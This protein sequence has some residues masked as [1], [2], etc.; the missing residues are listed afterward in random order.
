MP[1]FLRAAL[2]ALTLCAQDYKVGDRVEANDI[3]W[4]KGTIVGLG[5]GSMQGYFLVKYDA[6]SSQRY[7]KP[8]DLRPGG[9]PDAPKTYPAYNVGD[10][11]EGYDLGWYAARV[12]QVRPGK[13]APEYL[14]QYEKYNSAR[15]YHPKDMRAFAPQ[16]P[17]AQITTGPRTGKYPVYA[18]GANAAN[19]LFLTYLEILPGNKYRG[20]SGEGT[21][22]FNAATSTVEWLTGPLA[23]P[24]WGGKFSVEGK[25]HRIEL[26]AR[27]VATNSD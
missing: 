17:T 19:P 8:K 4:Y 1:K 25:R 10:R 20:F 6:Y 3:G 11:V 2:L 7:F 13:D 16:P 26:R 23:T 14:L 18:Y 24:D 21:Y 9:P 5:S 22:R 15:W 27:T 12:T